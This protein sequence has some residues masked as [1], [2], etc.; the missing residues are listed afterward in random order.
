MQPWKISVGLTAIICAGGLMLAGE[1]FSWIAP[2]FWMVLTDFWY[3]RLMVRRAGPG[4][5]DV[6]D[7]LRGAAHGTCRHGPE[8]GSDGAVHSA[9]GRRAN[10][11]CRED[12]NRKN[13]GSIREPSPGSSF[14]TT[15]EKPDEK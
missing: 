11:A 8:S 13:E 14:Q 12:W 5:A 9:R 2:Y 6:F 15:K 4:R 10:G 3:P 7:L 1:G